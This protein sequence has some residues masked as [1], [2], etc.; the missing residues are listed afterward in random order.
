MGDHGRCSVHSTFGLVPWMK[1]EK[2][3]GC[4]PDDAMTDCFI[5]VDL[6]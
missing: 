3:E 1:E 2:E 5:V 4:A 6:F